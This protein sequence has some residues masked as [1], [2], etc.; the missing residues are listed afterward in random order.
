[1]INHFKSQIDEYLEYLS[2]CEY[3]EECGYFINIALNYFEKTREDKCKVG[4]TSTAFPELFIRASGA[5][6]VYLFGGYEGNT[7]EVEEI[8]PQISDHAIKASMN[9]LFDEKMSFESSLKGVIVP[10]TND[11]NRKIA[12]YLKEKGYKVLSIEAVPYVLNQTAGNYIREQRVF[13]RNLTKLTK[14][15]ITKRRLLEASRKITASHKLFLRIDES[16]LETKLKIFLKETYYLTTDIDKW[17]SEMEVLL[18]IVPVARKQDE[19]LLLMGGQIQFPSYK[20]GLILEETGITNYRTQCCVPYPY[21]Y[22]SLDETQSLLGLYKQ[23]LDIHYKNQYS[24]ETLGNDILNFGKETK[25]VIFHLLK[26]QLLSAYYADKVEKNCIAQ[27]IPFL[28]IETD[29]T[30]ADKE[31]V[32]IRI[33]A[34]TELLKV[35]RR[36]EKSER[37]MA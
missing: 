21:D 22:S 36:S 37:K 23:I 8:F 25:A 35:R 17:Q 18:D 31:Q 34:F 2:D 29:Y 10:M 14:Q 16:D 32:K 27:N 28:C 24:S 6:P 7:N 11:S 20:I 19:A 1:M 9:L 13:L 12:T 30:K 5:T 33:E 4:V 3:I 26:G 15:W